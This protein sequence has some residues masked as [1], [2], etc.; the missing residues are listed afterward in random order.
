[1]AAAAVVA[2]KLSAGDEIAKL[3][4]GKRSKQPTARK[5]IRRVGFLFA[6]H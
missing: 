4:N 3:R 2:A 5:T 1:V 6:Q